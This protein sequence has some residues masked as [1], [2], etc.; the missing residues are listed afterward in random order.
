MLPKDTSKLGRQVT[1][2]F[3]LSIMMHQL[4]LSA[5]LWHVVV[6]HLLPGNEERKSPTWLIEELAW[7][8]GAN[9]T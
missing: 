1:Q 2:T 3:M 4:S 8:V 7:D 5:C 6:V 9:W